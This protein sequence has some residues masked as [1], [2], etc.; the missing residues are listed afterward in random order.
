[1]TACDVLVVESSTTALEAAV[2]GKMVVVVREHAGRILEH[3][4]AINPHVLLAIDALPAALAEIR[5][6]RLMPDLAAGRAAFERFCGP[7]DGHA[8]DRVAAAIASAQQSARDHS[9]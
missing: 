9:A 5:A 8:G 6:G 7:L 4:R 1:M 2:L 3:V